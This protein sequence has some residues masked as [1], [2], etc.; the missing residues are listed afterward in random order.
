MA[1]YTNT[2]FYAPQEET[3]FTYLGNTFELGNSGKYV[4]NTLEGGT[5]TNTSVIDQISVSGIRLSTQALLWNDSVISSSKTTNPNGNK[6][7]GGDGGA[8]NASGTLF[9]LGTTFSSNSIAGW[10]AYGHAYGGAVHAASAITIDAS[11]SGK[12]SYFIG[13]QAQGQGGA[14]YANGTATITGAT[15]ANNE[16]KQYH[17]GAV[18][19]GSTA[20]LTDV[21]FY[22][23]T[24]AR[25]GG[26]IYLNNSATISGSTF[27]GNA[28]AS[29]SNGIGGGAIHAY[30]NNVSISDSLFDGNTTSKLGGAIY[31]NT[32]KV[33]ISGS[34]F[35]Q[36]SDTIYNNAGTLKLSG[37]NLIGADI[38]SASAVTVDGIMT[39]INSEAI[40][41]PALNITSAEK[42]I[43]FK[44]SN[45]VTFSSQDLT[46]VNITID[47]PYMA[48]TLTVADGISF[49][50]IPQTI[51]VN[52][53]DAVLNGS[54]YVAQDSQYLQQLSFA[55]EA[56][57]L[58]TADKI[59]IGYD[60]GNGFDSFAT[61]E[62]FKN[63]GYNGF[64]GIIDEKGAVSATIYG[65]AGSDRI[66]VNGVLY[67]GVNKGNAAPTVWD[68]NTAVISQLSADERIFL[69]GG[70]IVFD[71]T[72]LSGVTLTNPQ[73]ATPNGDGAAWVVA[74]DA[75]AVIYGS[76]FA[77]NK[78]SGYGNNGHAS[79]SVIYSNS[80]I[81]ISG[82]EKNRS[83]FD[84]NTAQGRGAIYAA[85]GLNVTNADFTNNKSTNY[86][87]GAIWIA[88]NT[89][90]MIAN[91]VF[92]G[93][94]ATT[95]DGGAIYLY[96]NKTLDI[97]S[98]RFTDNAA[99]ISGGYGGG[100]VFVEKGN[101]NVSDSF[102]SGNTTAK[103]GGAIYIKAGTTTISGSTFATASDTIHIA[104][105]MLKFTGKNTLNATVSS[106]DS[107][108]VYG[109]NV[110]FTFGNADAINFAAITLSGTNT[111]TFNG[112]QVNFTGL[113]V[114]KVTITVDGADLTTGTVVATGVTGT[115]GEDDT[116]ANVENGYLTIDENGNLILNIVKDGVLEENS[117]GSVY[118]GGSEANDGTNITQTIASGLKQGTVFAG[119]E[120]GVDG[121]ITTTVTGGEIVKNL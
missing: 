80:F 86:H 23:N 65:A 112:A 117:S 92:S 70:T 69:N 7:P 62:D 27:S 12:N 105:G 98:S 21:M 59:K 36:D 24:S 72:T 104:G 95:R 114:S 35:A 45:S 53:M 66:S 110:N 4:G 89:D 57:T 60:S 87:A 46:G 55:D 121:K 74:A 85:D 19:A 2:D 96:S 28:G 38:V 22:K 33:T 75:S 16:S 91:S 47:V 106:A 97:S 14:V 17:G 52:G 39:F 58:R 108:A 83:V 78:V 48:G 49:S 40:E 37:E 31:I 111:L 67:T 8:L 115:L 18:A 76:T 11:E 100:A 61:Y 41:I 15:F 94:K 99:A 116:V 50:E 84:S 9:L 51:S 42:T 113:D 79:G 56:L 26:A 32:A 107:A 109:E 25:D 81:T 20:T 103:L 71:R 118:G 90:S 34:T 88:G 102:F 73:S 68:G 43:N 44:G 64:S 10:G 30:K 3:E 54:A 101:L 93:N 120:K 82:S 77:N 13:N 6:I 29:A 63:A 1:T 119:S 5:L